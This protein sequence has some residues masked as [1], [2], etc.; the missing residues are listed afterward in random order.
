[1]T[2]EK[3]LKVTGT[4]EVSWKDAIIQ[5]VSEAS[6]TIDYLTSVKV[7]DQRANISGKKITEYFVDLDISF[8]VERDRD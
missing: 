1:M 2:V 8:V 3:H 4:S 5:T 7:L 6:K